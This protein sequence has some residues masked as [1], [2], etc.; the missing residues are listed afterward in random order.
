M[1]GRALPWVPT[2]LKSPLWCQQRG[3][4][5]TPL[6]PTVRG[7]TAGHMAF[8]FWTILKEKAGVV[9]TETQKEVLGF[10]VN[11]FPEKAVHLGFLHT[12]LGSTVASWPLASGIA[13]Q[14]S[15]ITTCTCC[16][17]ETK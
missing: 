13:A 14:A 5:A 4:W 7:S 17:F 10:K 15:P 3:A 8:D 9:H 12:V 2:P 11:V 6:P 16:H 1:Q